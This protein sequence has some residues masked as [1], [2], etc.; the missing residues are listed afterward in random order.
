MALAIAACGGS[1]PHSQACPAW[2]VA[3][4]NAAFPGVALPELSVRYPGS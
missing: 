2:W 4:G 3:L 1:V